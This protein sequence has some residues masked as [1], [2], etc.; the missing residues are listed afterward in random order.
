MFIF[1]QIVVSFVKYSCL[2][3]FNLGSIIV[4]RELE[5][6]EIRIRAVWTLVRHM[7]LD[8]ATLV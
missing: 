3:I 1:I 6:S 2:G 5:L 4:C 7:Y 8:P